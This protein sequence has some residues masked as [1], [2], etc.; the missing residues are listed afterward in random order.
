MLC[1]DTK[2]TENG[3]L[4]GDPTETAL[5]DMAFKLGFEKNI[6]EENKR[7][8]ELP[9]DSERKLM[10]TINKVRRKIYSLYKRRS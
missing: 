1:N 5:T 7:K 10:T 6:I 2:I 8:E 4:T 3:E 9:F